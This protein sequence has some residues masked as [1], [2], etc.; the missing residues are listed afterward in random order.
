[1]AVRCSGSSTCRNGAYRLASLPS[2]ATSEACLVEATDHRPAVTMPRA[3]SFFTGHGAR[4]QARSQ[5]CERWVPGKQLIAAEAGQ[6]DLDAC[7]ADRTGDDVAIDAV[8]GG[9]V[10]GVE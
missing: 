2:L 9:L 7:F 3:T 4:P 6:G 10:H 1:M 5:R 8:T